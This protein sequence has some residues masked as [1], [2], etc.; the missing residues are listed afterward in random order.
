MP[1]SLAQT[2]DDEHAAAEKAGPAVEPSVASPELAPPEV[3]AAVKELDGDR[4]ATRQAAQRELIAIGAPALEL[5]AQTA[6]DGSLEAAT[7]SISILWTWANS[8]EQSLAI[9]S[10]EK[11]STL[12]NRPLEA[13]EAQ[14]R[15]ADVREAAAIAA[16]KELGGYVEMDRTFGM[17]GG[18]GTPLQITV[19][20]DWKGGTGGLT[21]IAA[22]RNATTLSLHGAPLGD[23]AVP[24]LEKLTNVK[25][26]EFFGQKFTPELVDKAR[27]KLPTTIIDIRKGGARLGIRGL[28]S[29]EIVANSPAA[30]AGLMVGD[31]ITEF[32]GKPITEFDEL[33]TEISNR[34]PGDTVTIKFLRGGE[35]REAKVTFDRWGDD[36]GAGR[37]IPDATPAEQ[38]LFG[39]APRLAPIP[40]VPFGQEVPTPAAPADPLPK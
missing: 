21:H 32:E 37:A 1:V 17:L 24:E 9:A 11:L 34:L 30:K 26:M 19:N 40:R 25:R 35:T 22:I 5:T 29:Q 13:S 27:E 28:D 36:A 4:Y 10:L 6:A 15:L 20:K 39:P 18:F 31:K 7:R 14:R 38:G 8:P 23:E 33:T 3:L 2:P 16:V 12:A